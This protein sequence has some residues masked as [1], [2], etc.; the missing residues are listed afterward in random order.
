MLALIL[1][2]LLLSARQDAP[3][4][5]ERLVQVVDQPRVARCMGQMVGF[6]NVPLRCVVQADA[7]MGECEVLSTN[8]AALQYSRVFRC[9]ASNV[10][11]YDPDGTPAVG[12]SVAIR[13]HGRT[14]FS[15]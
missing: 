5:A 15:D 6:S 13:V 14:V 7:T 3:A 12:R 11:V 10:R 1:A 8:R 2:G 4:D 9:M